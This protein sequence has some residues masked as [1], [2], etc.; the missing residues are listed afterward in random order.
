VQLKRLDE[1]DPISTD[2]T[3]YIINSRDLLVD[4]IYVADVNYQGEKDKKEFSAVDLNG[5]QDVQQVD[6]NESDNRM[7]QFDG[8][9]RIL[10]ANQTLNGEARRVGT[11]R[12]V[13]PISR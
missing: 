7:L 9:Q 3:G 6:G 13:R 4:D 11:Q 1:I 8:R 12:P 2:G 5:Q 10:I